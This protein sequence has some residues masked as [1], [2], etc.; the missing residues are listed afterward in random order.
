MEFLVTSIQKKNCQK[1]LFTS[2][3]SKKAH[4]LNEFTSTFD[5]K[6]RLKMRRTI[7]FKKKKKKKKKKE[8]KRGKLD[9]KN[10]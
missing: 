3:T 5:R 1:N 9:I 8:K 6:E 10:Y 7:N 4:V 2:Q